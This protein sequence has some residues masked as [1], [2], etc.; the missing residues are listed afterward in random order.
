MSKCSQTCTYQFTWAGI[1]AIL[2]FY[3]CGQDAE[4]EPKQLYHYT[5]WTAQLRNSDSHLSWEVLKDWEYPSPEVSVLSERLSW[6]F[7]NLECKE[8]SEML[9]VKCKQ[10]TMSSI[11]GHGPP[12]PYYCRAFY[13]LC[14]GNP[15]R[16]QTLRQLWNMGGK[17]P[18]NRETGDPSS[19]TMTD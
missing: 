17:T 3:S 2:M 10:S 4:N 13:I 19:S 9:T 6:W 18:G 1:S 8:S 14:I 16:I 15:F 11:L 7:L 12:D 5:E